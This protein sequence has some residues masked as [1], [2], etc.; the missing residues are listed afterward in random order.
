MDKFTSIRAGMALVPFDDEL[1]RLTLKVTGAGIRRYAVT[2]GERSRSFSGAEL[3]RGINL[4]KEFEENPMVAAFGA[5]KE[6]VSRKQAY[7]T[8]QIKELAHGPEGA[9][10]IE[11]TFAVTEK[12]RAPLEER[13]KASLQPVDH[14]IRIAAEGE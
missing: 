3:E 12:A 5:V 9:A 6:A 7:E 14:V 1:N 8:R 13:V 11:G 2:W 4:A 10:D